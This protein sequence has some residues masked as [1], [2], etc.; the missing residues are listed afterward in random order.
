MNN[1]SIASLILMPTVM[2]RAYTNLGSITIS[3]DFL[4]VCADYRKDLDEIALIKQ[5]KTAAFYYEFRE[6]LASRDFFFQEDYATLEEITDEQ[7]D[8]VIERIKEERGT[9]VL[10]RV[11]SARTLN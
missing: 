10:E 7:I 4:T 1:E 2:Q 6:F 9:H 11:D 3:E 8:H 5:Y